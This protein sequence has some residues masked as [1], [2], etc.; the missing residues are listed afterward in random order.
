[1]RILLVSQMWP[2]P[3]DPGLG[4]VVAQDARELERP[5][6]ELE[7]V[8]IDRR[9]GPRTKY[10]RLARD[11]V[12]A[13][14]RRRPDVVYAHFLA[15]AGVAGAA[16]GAAARAPL[17]LTAHGT[18]VA[19][20]RRR[21]ALRAVT[22]LGT[23][24]AAAVIAVSD[25]LRRR[26]VEALPEL[27]GRVEVIDCGVDLDRFHGRDAGAARAEVGWDGEPPHLLF[28]GAFD[29]RKNVVPLVDAFERLGRG[30]LALVGDGPLRARV[31]GRPG[32]RV[33]GR[34]PHERVAD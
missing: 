34:V 6:H 19:N 22:R 8:A 33:V 5:G 25:W 9:G 4:V 31:E 23:R 18:D 1:M 27:A 14:R 24:R 15:P 30:S 2:G 11:A 17:V 28:V 26:L 21:R 16:A 10:L 7:V 29:E 13:A 20:A 12:R 3:R 32:V